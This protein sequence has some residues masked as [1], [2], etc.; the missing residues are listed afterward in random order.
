MKKI[1][2]TIDKLTGLIWAVAKMRLSQRTKHMELK[3]INK[4]FKD[5]NFASDCSHNT[6]K[7]GAEMLDWIPPHS[8][9]KQ[10]LLYVPAKMLSMLNVYP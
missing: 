4:K 10:C 7:Q 8:F 3:S 9:K 5:K 6:L 1:L 2:F